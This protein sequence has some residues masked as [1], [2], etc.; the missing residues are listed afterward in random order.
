MKVWMVGS[1]MAP[2]AKVGGLADVLGALPQALVR[3]GSEV[4]VVLPHLPAM[5]SARWGIAPTGVSV[6]A[7]IGGQQQTAEVLEAQGA[8][9]VR[10]LFVNHPAYFHREGLYGTRAGDFP[11]NAE[12][13]AFFSSAALEA[14][15]RCAPGPDVVHSHDWQT[16][17]VP[18]LLRVPEHYGADPRFAGAVRIHTIH[19]LSYQGLFPGEV[20]PRLGIS[21]AHFNFLGLEFYGLLNFLKAG[22][23]YADALTTVSPT[24]AQEIQTLE[25]AWGLQGVLVERARDLHGILNGIDHEAWDP[26]NDE[27]LVRRY[28]RADLGPRKHNATALREEFGL[29]K[30]RRPLVGVVNRLVQQKGIDLLLALEPRMEE[31][32]LQWAVLGSGEAGYEAAVE[33]MARRHPG[34]FA[35]RIGFDDAVARRI[36]AGSDLFC[37]PSYFEPCGLGQ[38]IALRYGSLPVVRRTGGLADTVRD[39]FDPKGVGFVFDDPTPAALDAALVRARVFLGNSS[40]TV[41]ARR[42]GMALD[43]SWDASARRYLEVYREAA[44]RVTGDG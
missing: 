3:L 37:M 8:G 12:R 29:P 1:E 5:D 10:V 9:G 26:G 43:Y 27:A 34:T 6:S 15:A 38:M 13:F 42:R 7:W 19:N 18:F 36:Y 30:D 35:A 2:Y 23:V 21:W 33:D 16:G 32:G 31:L 11:D 14:A 4:T 40:R 28:S 20:L 22:L 39:L 41:A 24:Y 25:Y 17:L 44:G